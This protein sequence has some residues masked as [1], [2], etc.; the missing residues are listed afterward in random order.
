MVRV[1]VV[2]TVPFANDGITNVIINHF[3]F[4]DESVHMDF[5]FPNQLKEYALTEFIKKGSR[6]NVLAN[7]TRK[8]YQYWKQLNSLLK[9]ND[10]DVVH[11]HGNSS[12]MIIE[13]LASK[14]NKIPKRFAHVHAK[15]TKYPYLNMILHPLFKGMYTKALAPSQ[16]AGKYLFGED[17]FYIIK[18]GIPIENYIFTFEKRNRIRA[19][20]EFGDEDIVIGNIGR[21]AVE[22][23]QKYL[24]KLLKKLDNRKYKLLLIGE[25][26]LERD[27]KE[28]AKKYNLEK[29][30][31]FTGV[32]NDVPSLLSGMDFLVIPSL[33][34]GLGITA[35]EAQAAEL[36]VYI[37][38]NIPKDVFQTSLAIEFRLNE[39]DSLIRNIKD[40]KINNFKR[41]KNENNSFMKNSTYNI[42]NSTNVLLELYIK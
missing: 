19:E 3:R 31:F 38:E 1:L 14:K 16:E 36:P 9:K 26:P 25:G 6:V 40:L 41:D 2:S 4:I 18:N 27:L 24:L 8:P 30:V 22:K 12:T 17:G 35:I 13:L 21:L 23:N 10:Y 5:V 39:M 15:Y 29:Q 42:Y 34:E 28:L 32:R 37:S 11:V 20:F 33:S 7:R